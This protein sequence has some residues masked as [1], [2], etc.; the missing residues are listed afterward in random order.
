MGYVSDIIS[1]GLLLFTI[2]V[3]T[4]MEFP[5][6]NQAIGLMIRVFLNPRSSHTKNPPNGTWCCFA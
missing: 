2:P 6:V 1:N 5:Q 4:F 3:N